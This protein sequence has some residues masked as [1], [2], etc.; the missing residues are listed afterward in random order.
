[1][2][3]FFL[4]TFVVFKLNIVISLILSILLGILQVDGRYLNYVS[5]VDSRYMSGLYMFV[6]FGLLSIARLA[7]MSVSRNLAVSINIWFLGILGHFL[8]SFSLPIPV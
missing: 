3:L 7:I 2:Q 1:M 4:L 5:E 6:Q 8:F